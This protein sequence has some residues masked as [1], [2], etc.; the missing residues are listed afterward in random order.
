[1][2]KLFHSLIF[3]LSILLIT[4][5]SHSYSQVFS[6]LQS[7]RTAGKHNVELIPV[8]ST[9]NWNTDDKSEFL[10]NETGLQVNYGFSNSFDLG[11]R[12]Q[13]LWI[14]GSDYLD[15]QVQVGLEPTF[16]L[17]KNILAFS[18]PVHGFLESFIYGLHV[19]PTLL[20]SAPIIPDKMELTLSPKYIQTFC[21]DCGEFAAVNV[22]FAF[23]SDLNK[24]AF[25]SEYGHMYYLGSDYFINQF[26]FGISINTGSFRSRDTY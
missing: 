20:V 9:L 12:C 6:E 26:S 17:I 23:S 1:M 14:Q 5:P 21:G 2:K 11:L 7:A 25:R 4:F 13:G 15:F 19:Q 16:S 22:G 8:F 24:W 10:Q 3:F 18:L